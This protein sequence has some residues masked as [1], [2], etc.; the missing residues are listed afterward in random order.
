MAQGKRSRD[1]PSIDPRIDPE[2]TP[3]PHR[4]DGASRRPDMKRVMVRYKVK[5]DRVADNEKLVRAVYAQLAEEKADGLRYATFKL[6]D[7]VSFVHIA[8][9]ETADGRS[10]LPGFAAFEA[11]TANIAERCDE[12][13]AA[14]ELEEIGAYRF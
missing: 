13:P 11:F 3:A 1:D 6:P 7:G 8:T 5:A 4:R 14:V 10:P 9:I 12:P 2:S